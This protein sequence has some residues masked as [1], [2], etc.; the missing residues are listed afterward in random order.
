MMTTPN[1]ADT[2]RI[3]RKQTAT[4]STQVL[5]NQKNAHTEHYLGAESGADVSAVA[6][7]TAMLGQI[8]GG[9][10]R[11]L[12]RIGAGGMGEVFLA[13]RVEGDF[14]QQVALK[15]LLAGHVDSEHVLQRLLAERQILATL[16]HPN[17]ATL[18]GG[19][20]DA[21]GMPYLAM[22]YIEG[23]RIDSYCAR[24]ALPAK[25]RVMLFVKVCAAVAHAH[26]HLVVHRDIKPDNILVNASGEP[27]VL[28]FG[29]AKVLGDVPGIGSV[30]TE[31]G[32]S[33][34][35]QRYASP[36]QIGAQKV[37]TPSDVYALGVVLYE[38][39][40]GR[41]PYRDDDLHNARISYAISELDPPAPSRA[42]AATQL[43]IHA[44]QLRGDLDA[45]VLKALR[46]SPIDRYAS[47][48]LLSADLTR[49]LAGEHVD[50]LKG[51]LSYRWRRTA[52]RNWLAISAVT[53]VIALLAAMAWNLK[54][55][56][57]ATERERAA[58]AQTTQF[59][60]ELFLQ[61]DPTESENPQLSARALIDA[62]RAKL[63]QGFAG[64]NAVRESLVITLGEVYL[65]LGDV[66]AAREMLER[67]Y[68]DRIRLKPELRVQLSLAFARLQVALIE[69]KRALSV[70]AELAP[71][72]GN[73]V[74]RTQLALDA[75]AI[76]NDLPAVNVQLNVLDQLANNLPVTEKI[77]VIQGKLGVLSQIGEHERCVATI[78]TEIPALKNQMTRFQN[79]QVLRMQAGCLGDG[80]HLSE[81]LLVAD[82]ALVALVTQ[83]GTNSIHYADAL[84]V[85]AEILA[86]LSRFT[87]SDT[88][89]MRAFEIY[90]S[91][92]RPLAVASLLVS[93][94]RNLRNQG[95]VEIA[96][97][98]GEQALK[99]FDEKPLEMRD[100]RA[101]AHNVVALGYADVKRFDNA[102]KH[103]QLALD[104]VRG[105]APIEPAFILYNLGRLY[106]D[107]L[108]NADAGIAALAKAKTIFRENMGLDS[109]T[110]ANTQSNLGS[111]LALAGRLD[112]AKAELTGA[113]PVLLKIFGS[114]HVR[115]QSARKRLANL[116]AAIARGDRTPDIQVQ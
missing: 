6:R 55:R 25:A 65:N 10:Y 51:D 14:Q 11:V 5:A 20:S 77:K 7:A 52:R 21:R 53:A 93:R 105:L 57:D 73:A 89:L 79:A 115:T 4:A 76:L 84:E 62:G 110:F 66:A 108:K 58:D 107:D 23:E 78:L 94:A 116:H 22:E 104:A 90:Q 8:V 100:M 83:Q 82:Q 88:L 35:T 106:C 18:L 41:L 1:D 96:I 42:I 37:G 109:W 56:L 3:H 39:L 67:P 60:R 45:I 54:T 30:H 111:C 13:E 33:P 91:N 61:I 32:F 19:G 87:E 92:G 80:G 59:L 12:R 85:K 9:E 26:Q 68:A 103:Y 112:E 64:Q 69:P 71:G 17:I 43:G 74:A 99:I 27:K 63:E 46:K 98:L 75:S 49:Y 34:M 48:E 29:I 113:I 114:E 40:C 95:K 47:V 36:E 50:A 70:L 81:A 101:R 102:A 97:N 28:D 24:L 15:M 38:L 86:S 16:N 72:E 2:H 44:A 31:T